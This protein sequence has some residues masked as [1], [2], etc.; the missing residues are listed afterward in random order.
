VSI[1]LNINKPAHRTDITE[2]PKCSFFSIYDGHGGHICADF[3]KDA[4]HNIIIGQ[5][6]FPKDPAQALT[7]GCL[8]AERKFLDFAD[9]VKP[10]HERSGSCAIIVLIVE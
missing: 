9:K 6:T 10:V 7:T 1:I 8:E 5:E 4:L 3:L 2:W